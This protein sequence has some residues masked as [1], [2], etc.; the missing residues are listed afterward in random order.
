MVA[1]RRLFSWDKE[2]WH[3][4]SFSFG[5]FFSLYRADTKVTETSTA[6]H[7]KSCLGRGEGLWE[8]VALFSRPVWNDGASE[9]LSTLEHR[10]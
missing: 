4:P 7:V 5:L 3:G 10:S 9:M 1:L 2:V 8:A 6:G